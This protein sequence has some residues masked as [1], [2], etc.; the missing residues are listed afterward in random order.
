MKVVIAG[1]GSIGLLIGSYLAESGLGV[2]FF[3]RREEQAA[4]IREQGIRRVNG[5][6]SERIFVADAQTDI[7]K[8]PDM[9][10]WIVATKFGGVAT[11]VE[12][13]LSK[14]F[15]TIRSCLSKMVMDISTLSVG[16]VCQTSFLRQSSMEREDW[17]I[18]RS[19]ITG[20]VY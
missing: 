2:V 7:G 10:P 6:G 1:A 15:E 18:G 12:D 9:A 14:E 3:V 20:L 13:I 19:L 4:L 8:L 5:D 11:I 17:M 16:R